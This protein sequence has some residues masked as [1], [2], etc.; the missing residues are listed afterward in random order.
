MDKQPKIKI[1][2]LFVREGYIT[3][4]QLDEALIAQKAYSEYVPLGEVCARLKFLSRVDLRKILRT[5]QK[6]IF[7]GE[8]LVNMGLVT[9]N[10]MEQALK[11][12]K[13]EKKKIGI[14]LVDKGF[15]SAPELV[16]TLSIQLGIPKIT[17]DIKLIDTRLMKDLNQSFL[18]KN[19]F[20]PA[21]KEGNTLTVIMADPLDDDTLQVLG[22]FFHCKIE[23]AISTKS[24][25]VSAISQYFHKIELGG[26]AIVATDSD[27]KDLVIGGT[28]LR[29]QSG[30]SIVEIVNFLISSA[31]SEEASDIHIEPQ[32]A[33]LRVRYRIDGILHHKTDL[34]RSIIR[35]LISRI[36]VLCGLDISEKRRHQDGRIEARVMG[37]EIDLRVSTYASMWGENVVIRILHRQSALIDID[38]LGFSPVNRERY[39]KLLDYPSGIILATGPTGS[40]KTT[41]LYASITYLNGMDKMIITVEDPVEYTIE[42]VVQGRIDS[43][44]G[45]SYMDFLKSM[46]RQ[47]PD[48]LM[49]G[50]IR[51]PVAAEAAIQAALTGHKVFSTFH[52]DDTT[53]ALLR[54]MDMGIDT[55][56]ISSTVVS[57]LSQRL[58]RILCPKCKERY[59]PDKAI[60][61]SFSIHSIDVDRYTFYRPKGCSYCGHS[62]FKGR[63]AI[64]ELLVVN[65]AIRDAI[66]ARQPSTHIRVIAR[67]KADLISMRDDGF[68]KATCG[69]TSLEEIVRVVFYNEGDEMTSRSAEELVAMCSATG[70]E[71]FTDLGMPVKHNTTTNERDDDIL[72]IDPSNDIVEVFPEA[73]EAVEGAEK[74]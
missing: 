72:D 31:I 43:K 29:D 69:T 17:P 1:G 71:R 36:K 6:H 64:H 3:E 66:L 11:I 67:E 52:T 73:D 63:T 12:Q 49:I 47:D 15:L 35:P 68:Y 9:E 18:F 41:T 51:D 24:E 27:I 33:S 30:D 61:G 8:L 58:V 19:E 45:L 56:L 62:G 21:F 34:P 42:G 53:G 13:E 26:G 7:L 32:E 2:D 40:G 23:P 50:E 44:L 55:F 10:Q 22:S 5:F 28:D 48:V 57:V 59:T 70:E 60:L 25:I 54:L 37:K 14:I 20:I 39:M 74:D 4:E 38:E 46:M 65:D 16:D